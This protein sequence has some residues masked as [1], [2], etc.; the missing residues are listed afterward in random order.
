MGGSAGK[1]GRAVELSTNSTTQ[2]HIEQKNEHFE[3]TSTV[4]NVLTSTTELDVVDLFGIG[5]NETKKGIGN[6][7]PFRHRV[8]FHGPRGEVVRVW[9]NID[10]GAMR[11]VM[12]L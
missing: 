11:E 6:T 9:A 1:R 3:I 5:A 4:S 10:D 2:E 7:K 8:R 12:S